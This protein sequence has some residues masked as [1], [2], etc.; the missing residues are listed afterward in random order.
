MTPEYQLGTTGTPASIIV[1]FADALSPILSIISEKLNKFNSVF[2]TYFEN[3]EFSERNLYPGCI[4]SA[5][6]ISAAA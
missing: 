1:A 2:L 4:A 5:F 3:F 6:V